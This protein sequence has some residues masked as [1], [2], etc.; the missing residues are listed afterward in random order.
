VA[1][2]HRL[3]R[4]SPA[5]CAIAAAF[6]V[7]GACAAPGPLSET[8]GDIAIDRIVHAARDAHALD[9]VRELASIG[10]RLTG[11]RDDARAIDWALGK[12]SRAG[13]QAVHRE[14]WSIP[15][16]WHRGFAR[17]EMVAPERRAVPVS[18]YGWA[19]STPRGGV[20]ASLVRVD[21]AHIEREIARSSSTWRG[22]IVLVI[23]PAASDSLMAFAQLRRLVQAAQDA[24]ALGMIRRDPRPGG[25]HT[26]PVAYDGKAVELPAVDIGE[27]EARQLDRMT[28]AGETVRVHLE[29]SNTAT[30]VPVPTA[31]VIGELR[32]REHP[33]EIVLIG[34]HLD[35]WDL[36][37]GAVDD[38]VGV[39][40]VIGVARTLKALAV[41][42]RRS[43][44]FVLFTG[45][46]QGLLGSRAYVAAHRREIPNI[47]CALALDWG[48]GPIAGIPLSGHLE[49]APAF[50]AL[51]KRLAPLQPIRVGNGYSSFTDAYAFTVAGAPGIGLYQDSPG[52]GRVGHSADDTFERVDATALDRNVAITAA[53][54]MNL[55]D[56]RERVGASWDAAT[57]AA[58]LSRDG[59]RPA[60]EALGLWPP[61]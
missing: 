60:L 37:T 12:F 22:R 33:E 3:G 48:S 17:A 14:T 19:G 7:V 47:V 2:R 18:S 49:M 55:A 54:V 20:T 5:R 15:S 42:P 43:L 44:R 59:Q 28:A 29:V 40:T 53:L 45:E 23:P 30:S 13:L 6:A 32:G 21:G 51:A 27:T 52:Y 41:A 39:A 61:R 26:G 57:T 9:D 24:H 11:S 38:G 56:R 35:S 50:S 58:V 1:E 46:E 10:P 34:A 4:A 8:D 25:L 16:A 36:G 31:N